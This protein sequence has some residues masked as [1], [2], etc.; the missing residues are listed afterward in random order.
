MKSE[1]GRRKWEMKEGE[2]VGNEN[3]KVKKPIIGY[4]LFVIRLQYELLKA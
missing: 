3:E 4:W 2:K 1:G